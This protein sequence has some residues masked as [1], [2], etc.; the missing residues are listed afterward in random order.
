MLFICRV[1]VEITST[2]V[3]GFNP[4]TKAEGTVRGTRNV[5][6]IL[7]LY[8]ARIKKFQK[9]C[10]RYGTVLSRTGAYNI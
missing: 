7:R 4:C 5:F 8:S 6:K 1:Y 3:E 9:I 2:S 10:V